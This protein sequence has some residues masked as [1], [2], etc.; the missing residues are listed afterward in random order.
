MLKEHLDELLGL[1]HYQVFLDTSEEDGIP[2]GVKFDEY[3][4]Q[5]MAG[6]SVVLIII[7]NQWARII[8]ERKD[9]PDDFVR[10]E[11]EI[12]LKEG[13]K[14]LPVLCEGTAMPSPHELP[15][16]IRE[17][18]TINAAK[19]RMVKRDREND[20]SQI[21]HFIKMVCQNKQNIITVPSN[22]NSTSNGSSSDAPK[23]YHASLPGASP[24]GPLSVDEVVARVL[25]GADRLMLWWQGEAGWSEW[26]AVAEV[27]ARVEA[28]R[29]A[30]PPPLLAQ[31]TP[32]PPPPPRF[33]AGDRV[34]SK[35]GSVSFYE[36]VIPAP[37]GGTSFLMM[38]TQVTQKLYEAVMGTNPSRFKGAQKPLENVS[39]EDGV[40]FANALSRKLGLTP[41]YE[42]SDNNARFNEGANGFRLPFEAEWE[43][44]AKGGQGFKYA[45]SDNLS[46]VGWYGGWDGSGNVAELSGTRDVAKLKP[47]GYGLYDMSGNVDEWCADDYENPGQYRPGAGL[48]VVRGGSWG[49]SAG[50]CTVASRYGIS[51]VGRGL[52]LG[53]RLSRSL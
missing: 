4:R 9:H 15:S 50:N 22:K 11:V 41:A 34:S 28:K 13:I 52:N 31:V 10:I 48:R 23:K 14:I 39:W 51:P 38:E 5:Q 26:G 16:S 2:L 21:T 35:V 12:A 47:N 36:L 32:P 17:I 49:S 42:G 43:F 46:E 24:E 19:F 20:L 44:A 25:G 27:K 30:T 3:L 18:A 7:N 29:Q 1:T 40:K 8:N 33:S 53:L 37:P 45:G 6:S